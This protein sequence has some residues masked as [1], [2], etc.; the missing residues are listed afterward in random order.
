MLRKACHLGGGGT[1]AVHCAPSHH[2]TYPGCCASGYHPGT[3][4]GATGGCWTTAGGCTAARCCAINSWCCRLCCRICFL[5]SRFC[6]RVAC[7]VNR[8]YRA[9]RSLS[10]RKSTSPNVLIDSVFRMNPH[11]LLAGS[12]GASAD[13][14]QIVTAVLELSTRW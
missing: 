13:D 7:F 14:H 6:F 8:A 9:T 3:G 12:P 1:C 2:R 11:D 5:I 4:T 10:D